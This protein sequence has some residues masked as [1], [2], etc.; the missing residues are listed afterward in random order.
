MASSMPGQATDVR[1]QRI[2]KS[3]KVCY[4]HTVACLRFTYLIGRLYIS[5]NF[6][7][8]HTCQFQLWFAEVQV[9]KSKNTNLNIDNLHTIM[10]LQKMT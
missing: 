2:T 8:D 7:R 4:I 6:S 3:T 5:I 1:Q 10:I 9:K